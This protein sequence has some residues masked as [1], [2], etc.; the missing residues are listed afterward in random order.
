V[1]R[2]AAQYGARVGIDNRAAFQLALNAGCLDLR[3]APGRY[4]VAIPP[5]P[6]VPATLIMAAGA[7]IIGDRD[8]SELIAFTGNPQGGDWRGIQ[9][10]VA[11]LIDGVDLAV[12]SPGGM[13]GEQSHLIHV[14]GPLVG[15]ELANATL[16]HP[17]VAGSSRG[18][19][20]QIVGYPQHSANGAPDQR[21][22]NIHVHHVTFASCARSGVAVHSG[23]HGRLLPPDSDGEIHSSTRFDHNTF[24]DTAD[25]DLDEEGTGDVGGIDGGDVVE[26]DHN[27]HR[28]GAHVQSSLAVSIYPGSTWFHDN[29][30][31]GRGLDI[32]GGYHEVNG[33]TITQSMPNDAAPVVYVR[34]AGSTW[35]HNET[36]ARSPSAGTGPVFVAAQKI[37]AP[38][39]VQ[40]EYVHID[41]HTSGGSIGASGIVGFGLYHVTVVDDGPPMLRDIVRIEG[42]NGI[43][44]TGV[45]IMDSSFT[46]PGRRTISVSGSYAGVGSVAIVGNVATGTMTGLVCENTVATAKMGGISGPVVYSGN[47]M[48]A[49]PMCAPF[50]P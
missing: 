41:Q 18:D 33:N 29:T 23:L 31:N 10:G 6:R 20:L 27:D 28:V 3:G 46:G 26:W 12:D 2:P 22:W 25:Q 16:S 7:V 1:C 9:P 24:L 14:R 34:K 42:T 4:E 43:R 11:W 39:G 45:S 19:C 37:T 15:G 40:L 36:W 35:F 17:V 21:V 48:P 8:G 13:W 38:T 30:L 32:Y 5:M 49:A 44:T 47:T 50:G